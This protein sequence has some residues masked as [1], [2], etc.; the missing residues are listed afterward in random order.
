MMRRAPGPRPSPASRTKKTDTITPL[1]ADSL[2]RSIDLAAGLVNAVI[3]GTTLTRALEGSRVQHPDPA[4]NWGAV[5]DLAYGTLRDFGRGD[6]LLHCLMKKPLDDALQAMLLVAIHRLAQRPEQAHIIVDQTVNAV[7]E[8]APGLRGVTNGVLR[9]FVRQLETLQT[10]VDATPVARYCHPAWWIKRVR[11]DFPDTWE[12]ILA[13]GNTHPP[14]SL[15]VNARRLQRA[16]ALAL[17]DEAGIRYRALENGA[18]LLDT[19]CPVSQL[20]GFADG[21]FSVQDAGAQWAAR[22]LNPK[23]GERVLDACAAPGGKTAQLLEQYDVDLTAVE[24]DPVRTQRITDNLRRL[25]LEAHIEIA[26]CRSLDDWWDGRP[27]QRIL[28]DVPCSASGVVRRHPDIKWLRRHSDIA[29]FARQQVEILDVLWQTLAPGGTMLYVTCSVFVEENRTQITRFC[30][31]HDNARRI[32]IEDQ[33]ERI[34]LPT[35]EHDGFYYALL[36]KT[37]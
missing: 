11:A 24:V 33:F 9:N 30:A 10:Q 16:S 36:E 22:W 7:G 29:A 12:A 26:D 14:M 23:P 25:K 5:Q 3:N 4:I 19:P 2:A 15:R 27:F 28:A 18:L 21:V 8:K 13:A 34:L 32:T 37:P 35:A 20:P 6:A 17:L 31:R 1:P